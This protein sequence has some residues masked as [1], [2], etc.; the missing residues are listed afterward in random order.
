MF[1]FNLLIFINQLIYSSLGTLIL[2][3]LIDRA[4]SKVSNGGS[5]TKYEIAI[6]SVAFLELFWMNVIHFVN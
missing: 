3:S 1:H 2:I 4:I 6:G 5:K